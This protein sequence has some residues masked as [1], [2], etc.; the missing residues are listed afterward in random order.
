MPPEI[1]V[2]AET[3]KDAELTD[4]QAETAAAES[5]AA[6]AAEPA[7]SD[8]DDLELE[9]LRS[10]ADAEERGETQE[11]PK[12]QPETVQGQPGTQ[13]TV[14]AGTD[15]QRPAVVPHAVFHKK[16]VENKE[17]RDQIA[18]RDAELIRLRSAQPTVT[19]NKVA[20]INEALKAVAAKFDAGEISA[21][22]WEAERATLQDQRDEAREQEMMARLSRQQPANSGPS[23]DDL[24]FD[25]ETKALADKYGAA[26][27]AV[28][29]PFFA[30][31]LAEARSQ[32]EAEGV[33]LKGN[34]GTLALRERVGQMA[35]A[36]GPALIAASEAI[37]GK[38]AAKPGTQAPA[39]AP[40]NGPTPAQRAAK[41][42][43]QATMPPNIGAMTK[44]E[45]IGAEISE[46][47]LEGMDEED[48]LK[49]PV[50]QRNRLLGIS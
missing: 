2:D 40:R 15:D 29:E 3:G 43:M 12:P 41:L 11:P 50:S 46:A 17:L 1:L 6:T 44:A 19:Q 34:G 39:A 5:A 25:R 30:P 28:P 8:V 4:Q 48:I 47:T 35:V 23:A 33:T 38:P 31:L 10:A 16:I 42:E 14:P 24:V 45:D 37:Y 18:A 20:E 27:D 22:E 26:L 7:K 49:L 32:L 36:R 9:A 21:K 13:P